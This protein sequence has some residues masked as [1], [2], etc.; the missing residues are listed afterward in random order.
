[1]A[2]ESIPEQQR[3]LVELSL[4]SYKYV[5]SGTFVASLFNHTHTPHMYAHARTHTRTHTHTQTTG[6]QYS[7]WLYDLR[8]E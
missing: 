3:K 6:S 4:D 8:M 7:Q 1:M 5:W 2:N